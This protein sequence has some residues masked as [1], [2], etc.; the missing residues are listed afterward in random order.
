MGGAMRKHVVKA[1]VGLVVIGTAAVAL[2]AQWR[3]FRSEKFGFAML[4][5]PGTVWG[6]RDYGGGW[7]GIAT[8]TGVTEFVGIV[9]LKE[10]ASPDTLSSAPPRRTWSRT[11]RSTSSGTTS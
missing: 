8:K 7:G 4:V 2:A 3:V 10:W 6:A 1:L 11:A 9:K 5:P